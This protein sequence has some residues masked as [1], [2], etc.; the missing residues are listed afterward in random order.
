MGY[1]ISFLILDYKRENENIR[2]LLDSRIP[3]YCKD[4][5]EEIGIECFLREANIDLIHS[6]YPGWEYFFS[7]SGSINIPYVVTHHGGYECSQVDAEHLLKFLKLVTHWVYISEKN[8]TPF[9]GIPL[10]S[11]AFQKLP[12][13]VPL[14]H[15]AFLFTKDDLGIPDNAF[16]FGIASRGIREK[17]WEE[18]IKAFLEASR[19]SSEELFLLI[20][21]EGEEKERLSEIYKHRN[22]KFLGY[23]RNVHGFYK[24]CDCC[25]LPSRFAG[26]SF[27]LTLIESIQVGR[28]VIATDIGEIKNI[29]IDDNIVSGILIPFDKD[30]EKFVGNLAIAMLRMTNS[31][32]YNERISDIRK[33]QY[34]YDMSNVAAQYASIYEYCF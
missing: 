29:L 32:Y 2:N 13:A 3:V 30:D 21:G 4:F 34:K 27:P 11:S 24:I 22:I 33:V 1:I 16:V 6:H 17:G 23:Q 9:N 26:E 12:N 5:V 19:S 20:C 8:L 28:P 10:S 14:N 25:V 18:A 31:E 7:T 15:D